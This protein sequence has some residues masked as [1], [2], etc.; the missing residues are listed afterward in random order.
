MSGFSFDRDSLEYA[1]WG[2]EARRIGASELLTTAS[3]EPSLNEEAPAAQCVAPHQLNA[4][5]DSFGVL[6]PAYWEQPNASTATTPGLEDSLPALPAVEWELDYL[7]YS[8][9]GLEPAMTYDSGHG[10]NYDYGGDYPAPSQHDYEASLT[11]P[12]GL[13]PTPL[14]TLSQHCDGT[15]QDYSA[16]LVAPEPPLRTAPPDYFVPQIPQQYIDAYDYDYFLDGFEESQAQIAAPA[17]SA[18][19]PFVQPSAKPLSAIGRPNE[20]VGTPQAVTLKRKRG[21][22]PKGGK[23]KGKAREDQENVADN[24]SAVDHGHAEQGQDV[25]PRQGRPRKSAPGEQPVTHMRRRY[26]KNGPLSTCSL[27]NVTMLSPQGHSDVCTVRLPHAI[28]PDCGKE[29]ANDRGDSVE[30]H[31]KSGSCKGLPATQASTVG[32]TAWQGTQFT[33]THTMNGENG[34]THATYDANVGGVVGDHDDDYPSND[35]V[36]YENVAG[37][38]S[39]TLEDLPKPT[40]KGKGKAAR[41]KAKN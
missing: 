5:A 14:Q 36:E 30:R 8:G 24:S 33:Y 32:I 6:D 20:P 22:A 28:C 2:H 29:F 35:S 13:G 40:N 26:K 1:L 3:T 11:P 7:Y 38:S 19:P 23:G 16:A 41:S 34:A 25:N 10:G 4:P 21:A 17:I 39:V 15:L 27:C 12:S 37:P 31:R 9:A 18:P